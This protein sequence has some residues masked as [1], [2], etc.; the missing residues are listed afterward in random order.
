VLAAVICGRKFNGTLAMTY[1]KRSSAAAIAIAATLTPL[2]L[3]AQTP[4]YRVSQTI[5]LGA[6]DRWD[7]V[8]FDAS[9]D[10]VFV[11]HGTEVDAIDGGNGKLLGKVSGLPGNTH[12]VA[13][14][15]SSHRG[16]T[17]IGE[18]GQAVSFNLGTY[19]VEK[20][21]KAAEDAD[22][23]TYDPVSKHVFVINGDTGTITV[24]DPKT[25]AAVATLNV[26]GKLEYAVPGERGKIFV[27]GA[28]NQEL[29]E[30]DSIHNRV[31][32]RWPLAQCTSPHGLAVDVAAH[33]LFVSCLNKRLIVVNS[34]TGGIVA[35]VSIGDGSD[36]VAFDPTRKLIF[37]SNGKD[38]TLSVI[39]E[40][41]ADTF[42]AMGSIATAVSA[43]TMSVNPRTGRLYL[44]AAR[45]DTQSPAKQ[46]RLPIQPGSLE[47]LFLDPQ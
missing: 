46:G 26:G 36:A 43:R 13:L 25:D 29:I 24:I 8:V 28:G 47:L 30:I 9:A 10:R 22:A 14:V 44:A 45:V 19:A 15:E 40:Q 34:Q 21:T 33:R 5:E 20:F 41:D 38:G 18:S 35:Q 16:Y 32:A 12:G 4:V 3:Y 11:A 39:H 27:N 6:P 17:D 37:S 7:Y 42:V 23:I 31:A 2:T 1:S